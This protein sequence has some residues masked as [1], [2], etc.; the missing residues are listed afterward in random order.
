MTEQVGSTGEGAEQVAKN[1]S[2]NNKKLQSWA[3]PPK[4]IRFL[5]IILLVLGVFFRFVNLDRK[6]YWH[7]ELYTSLRISGFSQAEMMQQ[8]FNRPAI[9]VKDLQKYQYP[10]PEKNL[11]DSILR[12]GIPE[13]QLPPLYF[14]LTRFWIQMFGN[15]VAVTRS[16]SAFI[17]LLAFPCLY[18]LCL[19]LFDSSLTGWVAVGLMA[20]SPF[21]VLF[22]Q[23]ARPYSLW[24]LLILLSS[25][26][27]LRALRLKTK[28]SWLVYAVTLTLGFYSFLFFVLV[29]VGHGLYVL[30]IESF[31]ATKTLRAY[32]LSSVLGLIPFTPWIVFVITSWRIA[33]GGTSGTWSPKGVSLLALL[34]TW[35]INISRIFLDFTVDYTVI[36]KN[37]LSY[38]II[39]FVGY[40]IYFLCRHS[41]KQVWLFV[42]ILMGVT[43]LTL[44]LPDLIL[45][46]ILSGVL[47]YAVPS[48][49]GIQLAVAYLFARKISSIPTQFWQQ[50]LWL[51]AMLFVFSMGVLSSSLI[52]QAEFWWNKGADI[53]E[54]EMVRIINQASNPLLISERINIL[55]LSHQLD[56]KVGIQ[57]VYEKN[58]PKISEGFSEIFLYRPSEELRSGIEKEYKNKA[59]IVVEHTQKMD[60]V[61][62][63]TSSLWKLEKQ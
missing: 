40:S 33:A 9:A 12:S 46:G 25:A 48:I 44:I 41:S 55:A 15:S 54:P 7:D 49:L 3:L 37:P 32:L 13:P 19:E 27:L 26:S 22:A 59:R 51:M 4:Y 23:E 58:I 21:H 2:Q 34:Q 63:F 56:P 31:R 20:V 42:L 11:T 38:L 5:I 47:R 14:T 43:G 24:T 39:I 8:V 52:S 6:F 28:G 30:V 17:S 60:P 18:W 36:L 57:M 61:L 16:F 62:Q 45:R 53:K 35:V 1:A 50:K 29:A 10:N